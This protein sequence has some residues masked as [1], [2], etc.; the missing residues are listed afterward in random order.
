MSDDE[1]P[2]RRSSIIWDDSGRYRQ[3]SWREFRAESEST[4]GGLGVAAGDLLELVEYRPAPFREKTWTLRKAATELLSTAREDDDFRLLAK[5]CA[6]LVLQD[7]YLDAC[8]LLVRMRSKDD[9]LDA[10]R[11]AAV[12]NHLYEEGRSQLGMVLFGLN[13]FA[14]TLEP[15]TKTVDEI[16]ATGLLDA[17]VLA[18]ITG[19]KVFISYA[20]EDRALAR[21]VH[22]ALEEGGISSWLDEVR[23]VPGDEW[24]PEIDKAIESADFAVPCLSFTSVAKVGF[25]QAELK[26]LM[27]RQEFQPSGAA[28]VIPVRLEDCYVPKEFRK[29]QWLDLFPVVESGV[30]QLCSAVR[31]QWLRKGGG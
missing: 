27:R 22:Q 13:G 23:L 9:G 24:E 28:F 25:F 1:F 12:L 17:G 7:R 29:Y 5:I 16:S 3:L 2:P 14:E 18:M 21:R 11:V 20:K 10:H 4:P 31:A 6:V 15:T 26:R 8:W 19:P 30:E